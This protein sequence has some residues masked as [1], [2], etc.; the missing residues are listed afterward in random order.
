MHFNG[1]KLIGGLEEFY[2]TS[3]FLGSKMQKINFLKK[4][5]VLSVFFS[6]KV[7]VISNPSSHLKKT[8]TPGIWLMN[9]LFM[10]FLYKKAHFPHF[11][12]FSKLIN[13]TC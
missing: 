13:C 3:Q 6:I 7:H 10:I 5:R 8:K 1:L 4:M 11:P 2:I 9:D 12:I